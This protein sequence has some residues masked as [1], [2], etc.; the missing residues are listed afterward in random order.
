MRC[1]PDCCCFVV[2]FVHHTSWLGGVGACAVLLSRPAKTPTCPSWLACRLSSVVADQLVGLLGPHQPLIKRPSVEQPS[3]DRPSAASM[4]FTPFTKAYD[5]DE[6]RDIIRQGRTEIFCRY[7]EV[8]D[9]YAKGIAEIR[10]TYVS[11]GDYIKI[12]VLKYPSEAD[13]GSRKLKAR[14]AD[15][16]VSLTMTLIDNDYPYALHPEISHKVLWSQKILTR[17]QIIDF[18]KTQ[19]DLDKVEYQFFENPPHK[20]T[21]PEVQ[22]IHV[23]VRELPAVSS[24]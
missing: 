5:W 15:P 4:E 10:Q 6:V 22:H 17:Q 14:P 24:A 9:T 3:N 18:L 16:K 19:L 1:W 23:M 12:R 21:V 8:N 13:P 20:K 11:T 2:I 7:Q